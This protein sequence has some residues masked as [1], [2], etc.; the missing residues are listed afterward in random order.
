ML[1]ENQGLFSN[2]FETVTGKEVADIIS[3]NSFFS[4][5]KVVESE[6][7]NNIFNDTKPISIKISLIVAVVSKMEN[8]T[9]STAIYG[10]NLKNGVIRTKTSGNRFRFK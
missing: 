2:K 1:M 9:Y 7:I 3:E 5:E 10:K 4:M 6:T 8:P